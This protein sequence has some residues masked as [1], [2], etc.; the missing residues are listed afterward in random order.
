MLWV[1][2]RFLST[3]LDVLDVP[4]STANNVDLKIHFIVFPRRVWRPFPEWSW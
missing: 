3:Q 2:A 4:V 1:I